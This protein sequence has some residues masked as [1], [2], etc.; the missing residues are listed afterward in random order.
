MRKTSFLILLLIVSLVSIAHAQK[1]S[2]EQAEYFIGADPG[3]GNATP[4]A[5]ETGD[6]S[7]RLDTCKA[8]P[9]L[10]FGGSFFVRVKSSGF[11]DHNGAKVAGVW[12]LP[13]AVVFPTT[14]RLMNAQAKIVRPSLSYPLFETITAAS[15]SF[16]S[17]VQQLVCKIPADSLQVGDTLEVRLQ[18]KDELWGDWSLIPITSDLFAGVST[19][20]APSSAN[21]DIYPNPARDEF[22]ITVSNYTSGPLHYEIWDALGRTVERGEMASNTLSLS[23]RDLPAGVFTIRVSSNGFAQSREFVV[24]R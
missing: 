11:V 8:L 15:G 16:D 6:A 2:I 20:S 19:A 22:T 4:L 3:E 12:S 14:A 24:M 13:S 23:T 9:A 21:I 10:A 17:V 5:I 18:G 1:Q 7:I